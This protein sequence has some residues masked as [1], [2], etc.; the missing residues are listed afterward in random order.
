MPANSRWDLIRGLKGETLLSCSFT[1]SVPSIMETLISS[2]YLPITSPFPT[3]LATAQCFSSVRKFTLFF[4]R[5]ARGFETCFHRRTYNFFIK[6]AF[7]L[8]LVVLIFMICTKFKPSL[9]LRVWLL[10]SQASHIIFN[11]FNLMHYITFCIVQ[12]SKKKM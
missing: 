4:I 7:D 2:T 6:V 12:W 11:V 9:R 1:I 10:S 8:C 3:F 5:K